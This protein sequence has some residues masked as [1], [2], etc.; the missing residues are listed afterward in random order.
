MVIPVGGF[1]YLSAD[2][3]ALAE[4]I[5]DARTRTAAACCVGDELAS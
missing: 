2:L 3:V 4:V 5:A 1:G